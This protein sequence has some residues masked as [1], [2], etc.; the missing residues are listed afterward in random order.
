MLSNGGPFY[1]YYI[2]QDDNTFKEDKFLS[3]SMTFFPNKFNLKNKTLTTYVHGGA[4]LMVEHIY[5][6]DKTT[7]TWTEISHIEIDTCEGRQQ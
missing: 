7:N 6:L 2:Q 5:K 3:D 1:S 4:C